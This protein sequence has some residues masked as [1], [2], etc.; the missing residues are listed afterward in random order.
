MQKE[1][2]EH[3]TDLN[4]KS[5]RSSNLI[6]RFFC[7]PGCVNCICTLHYLSHH[8]SIQPINFEKGTNRLMHNI[9]HSLPMDILP[10]TARRDARGR[11]QIGGCDVV[12]LVKQY[13]S[14][15][16]VYDQGTMDA[17]LAEYHEALAQCW[18]TEAEVA[19]AAKAWLT[20]ATA[21]WAARGGLGMDV[22]S[23]GELWHVLQA[24]F[25][26]ERVHAHGN[27]KPDSFLRACVTAGVGQIALDHVREAER[28]AEICAE[29]GK[30]Q[31]V[32]LRLNPATAPDTHAS[33]QTG[34]ASSKFGLSIRDGSALQVAH[35]VEANPWLSWRGIHFH[36]GSQI[37]NTVSLCAA[38]RRVFDW[39]ANLPDELS[40]KPMEFSPGGGWAV[41]Y[42][43]NAPS[44][45][46][47]TAI[48]D[49]S[50]TILSHPAL[51][52]SDITQRVPKL[53]LEPGR[54]LVA[55]AGV[56]LYTVGALKQA[57]EVSYA[58]LDGG[59]ADNPR[60]ALYQAQY[61]ALLAN[62]TATHAESTISY[63]LAG[64]FCESG[65]VSIRDIN[66]P[67]LEEG[68]IIAVPVSG[69]YQLSMASNYNGAPRPAILWLHNGKAQLIQRRETHEMLW[70]RDVG[71]DF[72]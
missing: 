14:P 37:K 46:P 42:T 63:T 56:A 29:L 26:A 33:I 30:S 44:L 61:H 58:F 27:N 3:D 45:A 35:F 13:G 38:T 71:L 62:R 36:I 69:A 50:H 7:L 1:I 48:R 60:P 4:V 67:P 22:V 28:L 15:L 51:L 16:Y 32:W 70:A 64:P 20:V 18:P 57:D 55:R 41:P 49:L 24:G 40:R 8:S 52:E 2:Q 9:T 65:D 72:G 31:V 54:E 43:P 47:L 12:E 66:L 21:Q 10:V 11:L 53:I 6:W 5:A 68:H 19:Y 17:I 59:L 39:L 34:S 23:E 25:P